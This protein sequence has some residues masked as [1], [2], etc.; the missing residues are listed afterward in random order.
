ML[1]EGEPR[2]ELMKE[3]KVVDKIRV[4]R[5]DVQALKNLLA[6]LRVNR[7]ESYTIEKKEAA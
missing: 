4:G 1:I 7:D 2:F 3:G 6:M 5:Y